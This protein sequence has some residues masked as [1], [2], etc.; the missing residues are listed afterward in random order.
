MDKFKTVIRNLLL[1]TAG[2]FLCGIGI[3]GLRVPNEFI[4]GGISGLTL[5][6]Y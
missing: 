1:I 4:S 6:V 5:R 3:K 2:S